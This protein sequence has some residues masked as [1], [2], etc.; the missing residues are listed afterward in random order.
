M[1]WK[2]K[3]EHCGAREE[4]RKVPSDG[5]ELLDDFATTTER[6]A[7][8]PGGTPRQREENTVVE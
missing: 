6:V 8:M 4:V 2:L 5:E 1:R 3:E 7:W